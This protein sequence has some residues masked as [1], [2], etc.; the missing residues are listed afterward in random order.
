MINKKLITLAVAYLDFMGSVYFKTIDGD[1]ISV[2]G[3]EEQGYMSDSL[4][5]TVYNNPI[6]IVEAMYNKFSIIKIILD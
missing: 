3:G 4:G 5:N 2:G 1:C 6:Q